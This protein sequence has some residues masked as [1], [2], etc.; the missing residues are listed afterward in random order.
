MKDSLLY[1]EEAQEWCVKHRHPPPN[2]PPPLKPTQPEGLP[3][4]LPSPARHEWFSPATKKRAKKTVETQEMQS[5]KHV[6]NISEILS[7][8]SGL[9]S[10]KAPDP[11]GRLQQSHEEFSLTAT[12][13]M[14]ISMAFRA[15]SKHACS[16]RNA[17]FY[18]WLETVQRRNLQLSVLR[19]ILQRS[20]KI[21]LLV[22][23]HTWL[24]QAKSSKIVSY[25][26]RLDTI[27]RQ[28]VMDVDGRY[29]DFVSRLE[30]MRYENEVLLSN[31]LTKQSTEVMSELK[32]EVGRVQ[33]ELSK[34][35]DQ[36]KEAITPPKGKIGKDEEGGL[37]L[38]QT[39]FA[40][41]GFREHVSFFKSR[42][43]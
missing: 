41:G 18:R 38:G 24:N 33:K 21:S 27:Q 7:R 39:D 37:G 16:T 8:N 20:R 34:I 32:K 35:S 3:P 15:L 5:R 23:F 26:S 22:S 6:D 4:P 9:F 11:V 40:A 12:K 10:P 14:G 17:F 2:H 29:E 1:E 13:K 30:S 25:N 19:R 43:G 36:V 28:I 42:Y 31:S